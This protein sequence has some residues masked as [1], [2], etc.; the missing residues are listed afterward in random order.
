MGDIIS[1]KVAAASLKKDI[2][3]RAATP[4]GKAYPIPTNSVATPFKKDMSLFYLMDWPPLLE[5]GPLFYPRVQLLLYLRDGKGYIIL[6]KVAAAPF[7]K[8][9]F[10]LFEVAATSFEKGSIILPKG[11]ATPFT[12][13]IFI[14]FDGAATPFEKGCTILLNLGSGPLSHEGNLYFYLQLWPT[15]Y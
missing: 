11:A 13:D 10:I 7:T 5:R 14:L 4:F 9:T 8:D 3:N 12:K 6:P 1:A 2:F 15:L